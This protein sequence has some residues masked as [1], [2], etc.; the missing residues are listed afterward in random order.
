MAKVYIPKEARKIPQTG[1]ALRATFDIGILSF[2]SYG[3]SFPCC[4]RNL[5]LG[6]TPIPHIHFLVFLLDKNRKYQT[7]TLDLV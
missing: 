7:G 5:P 6:M 2:H 1:S 4:N 3:H